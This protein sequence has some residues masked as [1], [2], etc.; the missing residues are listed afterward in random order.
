M[1][2]YKLQITG[3]SLRYF[4]STLIK[5][6]VELYYIQEEKEKLIIIV[7]QDG[8]NKIKKMKGEL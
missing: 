2:K 1:N 8:Y 7:D 3:Y 6:K 4:L 5:E